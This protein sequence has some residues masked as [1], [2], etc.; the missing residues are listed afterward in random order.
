MY[1]LFIYIKYNYII[2]LSVERNAIKLCPVF[3][4]HLHLKN[5]KMQEGNRRDN[6]DEFTSVSDS[7]KDLPG[8][9]LHAAT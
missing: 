7:G 1:L 3:T 9:D 8:A 6:R 5:F 4:G 2:N